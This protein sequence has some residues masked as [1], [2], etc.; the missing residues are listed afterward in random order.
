MPDEIPP[1]SLGLG[2]NNESL[3]LLGATDRAA[4]M[5]TLLR[6][7]PGL[8]SETRA[9]DLARAV[10]HFAHGSDYRVIENPA[11][12]ANAYRAQIEREDPAAEWQEGVI[13]LRDYGVPD[14]NQIE[15]PKFAGGKLTFYAVDAFL[16]VPY[17][18]ETTNLDAAPTYTPMPLTPLPR[19][20]RPEPEPQITPLPDD[21]AARATV[22]VSDSPQPEEAGQKD[23]PAPAVED[24][25][26]RE[27]QAN[28]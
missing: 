23:E 20:P 26:D 25:T 22:N 27:E 24:D 12:F 28:V 18:V 13:R 10:N 8:A 9:L 16:G 21:S 14:F 5:A 2:D 3:V 6:L 1:L 4:D 11:E 17:K 15:V 7:A 19:P